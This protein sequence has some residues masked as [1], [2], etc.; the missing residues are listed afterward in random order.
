M[1]QLLFSDIIKSKLKGR[2][3]QAIEI[4]CHATSLEEIKTILQNNFGDRRS[5]EELFDELRSVTFITNTLDFYNDMK[6][7]LHRLNNKLVKPEDLE[8]AMDILFQAGYAHRLPTT[9]TIP[10]TIPTT[11]IIPTTISTTPTI[12]TTIPTT[13]PIPTSKP[14]KPQP[15]PS[16]Q[17]PN[18]RNHP[19]P[20]DIGKIEVAENFRN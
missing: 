8:Q 2:A 9:L 17:G 14:T 16:F 10:T 6:T 18:P 15:K 4:N 20:M 19:E 5:C 3:K 1:S 13:P 11:P 7:K 12:P